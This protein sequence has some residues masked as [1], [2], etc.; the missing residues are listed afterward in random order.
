MTGANFI[1]YLRPVYNTYSYHHFT[2][3]SFPIMSIQSFPIPFTSIAASPEWERCCFR[4]DQSGESGWWHELQIFQDF[5]NI[6]AIF[7][8]ISANFSNISA[9]FSNIS[10]NFSNIPAIFSNIS[11]IF[12]N[13]SS[14][15][16]NIYI[17][18]FQ[19]YA[20]YFQIY[21]QYCQIY[22]QYFQITL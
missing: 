2:A 9:I 8:N 5:C 7:S 19:I 11:A 10:A 20:Q 17:Q 21:V 6:S 12:T 15:V 13:I 1:L 16:S 14:I 3:L 4:I 22:V 18:Y